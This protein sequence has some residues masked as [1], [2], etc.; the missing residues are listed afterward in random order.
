MAL[1]SISWEK[2]GPKQHLVSF[3]DELGGQ[4]THKLIIPDILP[5]EFATNG[6]YAYDRL[7]AAILNAR[8]KAVR[9]AAR[10]A[11]EAEWDEAIF[12]DQA[13]VDA[14]LAQLQADID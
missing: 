7:K 6:E 2:L 3:D 4:L 14:T 1:L 10:A 9:R 13:K 11:E 5:E 8:A 12:E